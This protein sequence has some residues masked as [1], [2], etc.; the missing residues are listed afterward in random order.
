MYQIFTLDKSLNKS[1][2]KCKTVRI[3]ETSNK[4]YLNK[5]QKSEI[6]MTN[7]NGKGEDYEYQAD[8]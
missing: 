2:Q 3:Y 4:T 1:E 7:K 5:I 8:S 6:I